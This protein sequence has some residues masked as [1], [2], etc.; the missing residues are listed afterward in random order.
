MVL[1]V[2]RWVLLFLCSTV[3]FCSVRCIGV[4]AFCSLVILVYF[5]FV[6]SYLRSVVFVVSSCVCPIFVFIRTTVHSFSCAY[7]LAN[8]SFSS[9]VSFVFS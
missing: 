2:F 8:H 9:S 3:Y 7:D 1:L 5:D 6:Q 4:L